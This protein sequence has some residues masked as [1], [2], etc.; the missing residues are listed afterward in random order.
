MTNVQCQMF[1]MTL[2]NIMCN[3]GIPTVPLLLDSNND[4]GTNEG[5]AARHY[6]NVPQ[7]HNHLSFLIGSLDIASGASQGLSVNGKPPVSKT[8]TPRSS[9][10]RPDLFYEG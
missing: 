10:G 4:V 9:R 8:G 5:V 6:N 7:A 2:I 1:P 3:I